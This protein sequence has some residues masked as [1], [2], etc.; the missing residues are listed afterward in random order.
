MTD[1][2]VALERERQRGP[3]RHECDER[4]EER[5]LAMDFVERL[6]SIGCQ[7]HHLSV[8]DVE[9]FR[10]EM[11]DDFTNMAGGDGVGL[12]DCKRQHP[13]IPRSLNNPTTSSGRFMNAM[14]AFS[15]AI[16]SSPASLHGWL[17]CAGGVPLFL[18]TAG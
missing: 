8:D 1:G 5:T 12:D 4:P 7:S 17:F 16:I 9:S 14:P 3:R 6:R 13:F 15:K 2:V 10:F 11:R 18:C